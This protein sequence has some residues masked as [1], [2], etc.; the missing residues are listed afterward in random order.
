MTQGV[1]AD[2]RLTS[3]ARAHAVRRVLWLVLA[4][5]LAVT[6]VKIGL[7]L[8]TGALAVVADGFHS[9][10]DSTSNLVGLLGVWVAARPADANH[11]YGH[12]KF[13]AIATLGIGGL[14]LIAAF[15]IGRG[16]VVRLLGSAEIARVSPTA[17]GLMALT[18]VVNVGITLYEA[19]ASRRLNSLVLAA[20]A[21]NT[22]ADLFVTLSVI[23]ALIGTRLGLAWLDPLVAGAV[24][25]LLFRAAFDI[26]RST[27][28]VLTDQAVADPSVVGNI[29]QSVPGVTA[30]SA[31]RSRGRDDAAHVDLNIRVNP[32]MDANQAHSVASEVEHRIA[33]A[34]PGV[35]DTVVHIEPDW[36]EQPASALEE[37]TLKLRALALGQGLGLHD[38]HAHIERDGSYSVE[39]HLEMA[40]ELSLED[41]H[42]AADQFE[43][44]ARAALPK[45]R[46]IV[47]HLEPLPTSLPDEEARLSPA[48]LAR[49]QARL[50][51]MAN[52]VA[53][54]GACHDVQVHEVAGHLTATL[55][56]TQ[57]PE[58]P[59]IQAHTL[60]ER[61]ERE[62]RAREPSLNRVVVHVEP[63]EAHHTE[64]Q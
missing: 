24:V 17:I 9:L 60:A 16:A 33:E 36:P 7:G 42:T 45:L 28:G 1:Q 6:A 30:V 43:L 20:D 23:G 40:A 64:A 52:A 29:A 53:G 41:A 25:L 27:S 37:L 15:E 47:T 62:L 8:Y 4:F 61:I 34:M 63:P 39:M 5:N 18:F 21:A 22:R 59:L 38:L 13:E 31:V 10:V 48:Q 58:T 12:Q 14:L 44:R 26:L 50:I 2:A 32:A 49:L 11:P 46:S 35:V 56:V 3:A 51:A 54:K 55:H 57:P 19:R